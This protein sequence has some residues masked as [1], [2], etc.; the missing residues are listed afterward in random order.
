MLDPESPF[1][2]QVARQVGHWTL[3][4]ARLQRL[5][6]LAAQSAWQGLENYLGV[7]LRDCLKETIVRLQ[8]EALDLQRELLCARTETDLDRVRQRIVEFRQRYLRT[9]TTLDFFGDAVNSRTNAHIA[10]LL[11][12]CD[13]LA[14]HS[15]RQILEPMG[16]QTP[17][18]LT[19]IDQGLGASILKAGLRLWDGDT[20]S[21]VAAIKVTRHNLFRPTAII[22]EA[23]HQ[24]AHII[25]WNRALSTALETGLLPHSSALARVWSNWASEI[26]ADAFAFVHTGYAA[27]ASLH[28]VLS[29]SD[30]F[31]FNFDPYDPHPISYLR[32]LLGVM[33]CRHFFGQGPWDGLGEAWQNA[34]PLIRASG[35]VRE[36][37]E[38]S[39]PL[40]EDIVILIL[41]RPF[42][43]FGH[44][45]LT[46]VLHPDCV[47]WEALEGLANLAKD[48][49]ELAP[50][51]LELECVRLLA[52]TG[53]Q[54]ATKPDQ[55]TKILQ[56]QE[57]WMRR[58]G[59]NQ[60]TP[61]FKTGG[62][63]YEYRTT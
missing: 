1:R 51:W 48:I 16:Y 47:K 12:G 29:G 9:E 2:L 6:D 63:S 28:D 46:D 41:C 37:V 36:L 54:A 32:V 15:M 10:T 17:P 26:A 50:E 20:F 25:D 55:I 14:M 61:Q 57:E 49:F 39:I 35:M 18:V 24:V 23:G 30:P 56:E 21:P 40:L 44:R 13:K 33:M 42:K 31:V 7:A 8:W 4:A 52:L 38:R 27:V 53:W 34:Y 45:K 60:V 11:R 62:I 3:A 22:H 5:E 43:A 58:L 19:Y 59:M